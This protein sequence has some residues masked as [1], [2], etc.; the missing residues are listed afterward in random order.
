MED[1]VIVV[2]EKGNE[3]EMTVL[4][5]YCN[6]ETE[7]NY[8]FYYDDEQ[9]EIDVLVHIFDELGNLIEITDEQ[10]WEFVNEVFESFMSQ[11]EEE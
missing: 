11:S 3:K 4:F 1:I 8:V 7:T 10:E 5:T 6:D 2:D 9:E